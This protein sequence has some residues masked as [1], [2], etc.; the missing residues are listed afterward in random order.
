MKRFFPAVGFAALFALSA[1]ADLNIGTGAFTADGDIAAA[2]SVQAADPFA[3]A[4]RT[5]YL[6]FAEYERDVEYDWRDSGF[7]AAKALAAGS[8]SVPEVS[9]MSRWQL[10]ASAVERFESGSAMLASVFEA[11][12]RTSNPEAASR[13]QTFFECWA[14]E[15]E[16]N[17]Q[18]DRIDYCW[19][20][21]EAAIAELQVAEVAEPPASDYLV[22]FDFDQTAIRNDSALILDRVIEAFSALGASGMS[23][24]GHTDRAGANAYNQ[25]LSESRALAVRDYLVSK[26]VPAGDMTTAGKGESDPRVPTPDG[27]REQENRRVEINIL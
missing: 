11:G 24:T 25:S 4:L 9:P 10:P 19:S 6:T 2:R 23:L 16:E 18:Q 14:E 21:F 13:A 8:G 7:H 26:G 20:G 22:F 12:A 27:V 3:E 17:W 1:C 5:D 15:Q